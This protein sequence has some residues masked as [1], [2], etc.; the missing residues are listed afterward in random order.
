MS[1][2]SVDLVISANV[3]NAGT[4]TVGYP[5]GFSMGSFRQSGGKHELRV[6]GVAYTVQNGGISVALGATAATVTWSGGYTLMAG[7]IG[8][9]GFD[10]V[11]ALLNAERL[12]VPNNVAKGDVYEVNIGQPLTLS[13]NGITTVQL[14]GAAGNLPLSAAV[15]GVFRLDVP[16][17]VTLTVATTDHSARTF[18]IFGTDQY[19]M[20]MRQNLAGPNNSTV[21]TT[22]AFSTVT[23][24]AV[25]G[26]LAT[27]GVSVGWGNTYGLPFRLAR[28]GH[29]ISGDLDGAANAPTA[30]AGLNVRP[31][32]TNGDVRGTVSMA[33]AADGTRTFS[34]LVF[35]DASDRG[36]P[37]FNG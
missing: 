3:A 25:D 13:A 36:F 9:F 35:G 7:T 32:A 18:T 34:V 22:R 21:S 6:N 4:F 28:L 11:G 19:G 30:I 1:F 24:V 20:P 15:N 14:M 10:K 37:Q 17:I 8:V 16:R 29:V 12:D 23:Q 31:T 27:N 5:V 2:Q 26:A 33:T